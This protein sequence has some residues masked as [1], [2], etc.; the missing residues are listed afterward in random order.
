[1][2]I[3]LILEC[4]VRLPEGYPVIHPE[5]CVE[6]TVSDVSGLNLHTAE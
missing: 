1:M 2:S 5:F 6:E 4:D 3:F